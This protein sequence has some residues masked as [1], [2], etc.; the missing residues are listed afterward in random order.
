ME[1]AWS[2]IG[3]PADNLVYNQVFTAKTFPM[4][5]LSAIATTVTKVELPEHTHGVKLRAY[6]GSVWYTLPDVSAPV[7]PGPIP[8]PTS[9]LVIPDAAAA[10]GDVLLPDREQMAALPLG[11]LQYAVMLMSDT[12]NVSV[13]ITALVEG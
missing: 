5:V 6:G 10:L 11:G 9:A 2:A 4:V 8:S 7:P 13:L 1:S 12:P 3:I